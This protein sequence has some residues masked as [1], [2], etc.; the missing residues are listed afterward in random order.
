MAEEDENK[1]SKMR[2]ELTTKEVGVQSSMPEKLD[3]TGQFCRHNGLSSEQ[4]QSSNA[5][6]NAFNLYATPIHNRFFYI[7][8]L[9][10]FQQQLQRQKQILQQQPGFLPVQQIQ[11][12]NERNNF[13]EDPLVYTNIV[14]Q[15]I[16]NT[17]A[18][19]TKIE[20]MNSNNIYCSCSPYI[21]VPTEDPEDNPV[22]E[23]RGACSSTAQ[24]FPINNSQYSSNS[25]FD[26]NNPRN[27][28]IF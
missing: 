1:K 6:N 5:R 4:T 12:S 23:P 14:N 11:A 8:Q 27:F 2:R 21:S 20:R 19:G 24:G 9:Q 22:W 28:H 16:E 17:N 26:P 7:Q 25:R 10:Q 15:N 13:Q 18:N 3:E